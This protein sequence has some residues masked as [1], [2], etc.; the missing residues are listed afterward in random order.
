MNPEV[1]DLSDRATAHHALGDQARLRIVDALS[2]SDR[3][4][5]ELRDLIGAD[6]N[7]LAFHL[8]VLEDAGLV[9]RHVSEG[10]RRRKY[11]TLRAS[12]LEGLTASAVPRIR[13][14]LFVCTHNSA[15]SQFAAG[16]WRKATGDAGESAGS[17][18]ADRVHPLAIEAAAPYGVDLERARPRGYDDVRRVPKVVV[19]VCD[20]AM[21]AKPPFDVPLVHW[22]IAD[23]AGGNRAQF[24]TAFADIAD[25]V[26]RLTR[27][28][29]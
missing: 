1:I 22:S 16:L 10:D 17:R 19:S 4:P 29:A 26:G 5:G 27:L 8:R 28:A 24:E 15:R 13:Q 6:W 7:L 9:G 11:V 23:P 14:P 25:R 12:N 20:R 3:T 18:P 21:E 2:V